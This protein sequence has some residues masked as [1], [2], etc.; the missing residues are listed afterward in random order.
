MNE[1]QIKLLNDVEEKAAEATRKEI[2]AFKENLPEY[3]T[4]EDLEAKFKGLKDTVDKLEL[5]ELKKELETTKEAVEI[6][7][8]A[9]K[10]FQDEAKEIKQIDTCD[11]IRK[12]LID[13][14]EE[15]EAFKTT[16]QKSHS[17]S[18]VLKASTVISSA[19]SGD[20]NA[21]RLSDIGTLQ[22]RKPYLRELFS[23]GSIDANNHNAIRYVDQANRT[24]GAAAFAE[25]AAIPQSDIDWIE[26]TIPIEEYGHFVKVSK[27]MLNNIDFTNTQINNE[28]IKGLNLKIDA[29]LL[30]GD[31]ETPNLVGLSTFATAFAAGSYA[32]TIQ[33]AQLYD[34]I[35]VIGAQL[36]TSAD[37]IGNGVLSNPLDATTKMKLQKDGENNYISP[38]FVM[39]TPN[40]MS[41]DGMRSIS[42]SGVAANALYVGDFTRGTVYSNNQFEIAFGFEDDDFTR[43][44]VTIRIIES[45]CLLVRYV[46]YGAFRYVSNINNSLSAIEELLD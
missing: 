2:A 5:P 24:E 33:D 44:L 9:L 21:M 46:D 10:K 15:I 17:V 43:N 32:G 31:G 40:G 42:N 37:Y 3:A 38:P 25:G 8:L 28:L 6:Q 4:P 7:S 23:P 29:D 16:G 26:R 14:K 30:T 34:L 45:I 22:Q 11:L 20:Y 19:V 18:M 12:N 35:A 39:N 36:Q 27:R 41:V 1:E 13:N